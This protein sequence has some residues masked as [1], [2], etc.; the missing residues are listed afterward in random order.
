MMYIRNL[1]FIFFYKVKYKLNIRNYKLYSF[2]RI[3]EK[4]F[5][6]EKDFSFIQVGANDGVSFDDLYSFVTNRNSKGVVIEPIKEYFNELVANYKNFDNIKPVNM[7]VYINK[8]V[9]KIH[10]INPDRISNYP[11]WVK[12]IASL[13]KEHHKKTDISQEDMI[14]EDVNADHLMK[15]VRKNY[16]GDIKKLDFLQVDTEGFDYQVIKMIDFEI[17]T[18]KI[19]KF[20]HVN[21]TEKEIKELNVMLSNKGY[22]M[23][24]EGGDTI[25]IDLKRVFL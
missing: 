3:M 7:A 12:G 1:L 21:V 8:T 14:T 11:D 24:N 23:F 17:M 15:I 9:L 22:K 20:E 16:N 25:A 5:K 6:K 13:D 10:K 19:L 2:E 18:P 4:T